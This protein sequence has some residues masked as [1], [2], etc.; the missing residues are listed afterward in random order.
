ML[1]CSVTESELNAGDPVLFIPWILRKGNR[2]IRANEC[3]IILARGVKFLHNII[4]F[5]QPKA[6]RMLALGFIL[7]ASLLLLLQNY[8]GSTELVAVGQISAAGEKT[9]R[10]KVAASVPVNEQSSV[11]VNVSRLLR[12]K[13]LGQG[14]N[15]EFLAVINRRG[16]RKVFER[17]YILAAPEAE[18]L[19]GVVADEPGPLAV[20]TKPELV[21]MKGLDRYGY[22]LAQPVWAKQK[23]PGANLVYYQTGT[24]D[25]VKEIL[26]GGEP[27]CPDLY[28]MDA[29]SQLV[30]IREIGGSFLT[31]PEFLRR[32]ALTLYVLAVLSAI[33]AVVSWKWTA[34]ANA[35]R[36]IWD[37][38]SRRGRKASN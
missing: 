18:D 11:T 29:N 30:G 7:L 17:I 13:L 12:K 8:Y 24:F 31:F 3:N 28:L 21:E 27:F 26:D 22:R 35:G 25:A 15:A 16:E 5:F 33:G 20:G 9:V 2:P 6:L 37:Q 14:D 19:K 1:D 36:R 4:A 10:L 38:V 32:T 23:M 34:L